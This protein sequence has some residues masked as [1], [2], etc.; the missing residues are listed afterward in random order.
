MTGKPQDM[1]SDWQA[2]IDL[3]QKA[4]WVCLERL[5]KVHFVIGL[6]AIILSTLAGTALLL[7]TENVVARMTAGFIGLLSAVLSG[8]QTFYNHARRSGMH[9][10]ASTQLSQ[11]RRQ[12][13][14]LDK[15]PPRY[16]KTQTEILLHIDERLLRIEET[17]PAMDKEIIRQIR[18]RGQN[19]DVLVKAMKEKR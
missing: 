19:S 12:L 6:S 4:H 18:G 7:G 3:N 16:L 2:R 9:R 8:I 14:A 5:D 10:A 11:L 17:A 13:E 1:I 15:L